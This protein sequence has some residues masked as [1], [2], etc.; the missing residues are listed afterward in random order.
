MAPV[1]T[2]K[3][4][5]KREKLKQLGLY[6]E[7]KAKNRE[8]N[9]KYRENLKTK[10]DKMKQ[11]DKAILTDQKGTQ[12]RLRKRK[13]QAK[14]RAQTATSTKK[15]GYTT[16]QSLTWAMNKV[17]HCLPKS[18]GKKGEVVKMLFQQLDTDKEENAYWKERIDQIAT[19]TI[20]KAKMFYKRDNISRILPGKCDMVTVRTEQGKQKF[21]K[22]HLYVSLREK[23]NTIY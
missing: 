15:S 10:F 6:E 4:Q 20:D 17:K 5:R 23:H 16:Q 22:L 7:H 13:Y 11:G 19:E 9:R 1:S 14:K 2:V 12:E 8:H 21:Q 18:P 3:C